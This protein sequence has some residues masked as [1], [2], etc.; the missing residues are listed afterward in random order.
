MSCYFSLDSELVSSTVIDMNIR[1]CLYLIVLSCSP[2]SQ[3][4]YSQR[5]SAKL[6][7]ELLHP[8][9]HVLSQALLCALH[10][11]CRT[12]HHLGLAF[13]MLTCWQSLLSVWLNFHSI[14][15]HSWLHHFLSPGE[16][17]L[18]ICE[19]STGPFSSSSREILCSLPKQQQLSSVAGLHSWWVV[20][21]RLLAGKKDT[22]PQFCFISLLA[23]M[24]FCKEVLEHSL[25]NVFCV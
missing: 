20:L 5:I 25:Q 6:F 19:Y 12:H 17:S 8:C 13:K 3:R 9:Q 10:S 11:L 7:S 4:H 22:G 18:Q 23:A 1:P 24:F 2:P 16:F 15:L 21:P 14:F